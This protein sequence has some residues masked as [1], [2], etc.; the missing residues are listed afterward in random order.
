M[1]ILLIEPDVELR[2]AAAEGLSDLG[3]AVQAV[4]DARR[5]LEWLLAPANALPEVLVVDLPPP[6]AAMTWFFEEAKSRPRTTSIPIIGTVA[7][8][9]VPA[10]VARFCAHFVWK[11]YTLAALEEG[12][13]FVL[14]T[15][16]C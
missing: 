12:I 16:V 10:E 7:S 11:P 1:H 6:I 4:A 5:G 15:R 14:R 2:D 9:G 13:A 8:G 3:H